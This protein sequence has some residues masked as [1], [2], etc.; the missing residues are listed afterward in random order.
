MTVLIIKFPAQKVGDGG[1]VQARRQLRNAA[2]T[3]TDDENEDGENPAA[4]GS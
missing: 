4:N 1:G 3:A 2:A